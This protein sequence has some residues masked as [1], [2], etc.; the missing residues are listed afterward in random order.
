[1]KDEGFEEVSFSSK[2]EFL[3]PSNSIPST[4]RNPYK[5]SERLFNHLH[6]RP[7]STHQKCKAT[8]DLRKSSLQPPTIGSSGSKQMA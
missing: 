7:T 2:F 3:L 4:Q 1:M 6:Q 8:S 5:L